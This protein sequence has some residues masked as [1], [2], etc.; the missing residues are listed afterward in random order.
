MDI[1]ALKKA[2]KGVVAAQGD[3]NFAELIHGNGRPLHDA[4]KRVSTGS[5]L[6][7]MAVRI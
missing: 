7:D 4:S 6:R 1:D 3:A 5:M 2:C